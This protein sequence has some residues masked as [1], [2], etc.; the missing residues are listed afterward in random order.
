MNNK[1]Q[2]SIGN[3]IFVFLLFFSFSI[4]AAPPPLPGNPQPPALPGNPNQ[5][6]ALPGEQPPMEPSPG[7]CKQMPEMEGCP[8]PVLPGIPSNG[9]LRGSNY[10]FSYKPNGQAPGIEEF[11]KLG[12]CTGLKES[13]TYSYSTATKTKTISSDNIRTYHL[14]I[15][16][17][18][19]DAATGKTFMKA[20]LSQEEDGVKCGNLSHFSVEELNAKKRAIN[21]PPLFFVEGE[22]AKI[23]VRN[24]SDLPMTI[25]WHG[26]ILPNNQDGVPGITQNPIQPHSEF[27][28]QFYLQQN[29]TYWYHP[30]D[31]NEQHTKG[32]FIIFPKPGKEMITTIPSSNPAIETRYNHDRVILLTD[33]KKREPLKILNQLR[34]NQSAYAFDSKISRGIIEQF[35]CFDEF[36]ANFKNMKMF[37]MDKAD[38]WYDSF[39][40]NDET[41]LNCG[42]LGDNLEFPRR[43]KAGQKFQ[44]ISEFSKIKT[45]ER[46][47][48]RIINSSASTYFFVDYG[49]SK[50]LEPNQKTDMLIVAKDGE[51]VEP[52]YANQLKM[53]MGETY[54]VIVDVPEENTVYELRIKSIDDFKSERLARLLIGNT[55]SHIDQQESSSFLGLDLGSMFSSNGDS[56]SQDRVV[57]QAYDVP[58]QLCGPFP[59]ND[60]EP[61]EP[62]YAELNRRFEPGFADEFPYARGTRIVNYNL[63]LS[64]NMDDYHWQINGESGTKIE[65]DPGGSP[66]LT[67]IEGARN[68][69]TIKNTMMMGM[70]NHPWHLHGNFFRIVDPDDIGKA[71][72]DEI[73][74]KK[75]LLHTATISPGQTM[76][77]EI[78]ADPKYRGAWM[79]HCHNLYH[80]ANVMMMYLKYNTYDGKN[81]PHL[82]KMG[83]Q[84]AGHRGDWS[85]WDSIVNVSGQYV[86]LAGGSHAGT[87]GEG[88][89]VQFNY[90]G[91]LGGNN[92]YIDAIASA[93]KNLIGNKDYSISTTVK[94][95]MRVNECVYIDLSVEKDNTSRTSSAYLGKTIRVYNSEYKVIDMAV[96]AQYETDNET[97]QSKVDPAGRLTGAYTLPLGTLGVLPPGM[98]VTATAKGG[99]EGAYCG[100]AFAQFMAKLKVSPNVTF[101][102]IDCK[103]STDREETRCFANVMI[104]SDPINFGQGH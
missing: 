96:G 38:V 21:A 12:Y 77:L 36:M 63:D 8:P 95:C 1:L 16:S 15:S 74:A 51:P 46:V 101:T 56:N 67:I 53:G 17:D 59:E 41:C 30:H 47:R 18:D 45:G 91:N 4:V 102:L 93:S 71:N 81:L 98:V 72:E 88:V 34:N 66:Y 86:T 85:W 68:R 2:I 100:D 54:D 80:M 3:G 82:H 6:P 92:G 94:H 28:Y 69:I 32:A 76:I 87:H 57:K 40:I 79:F 89:D 55:G 49:N 78:Y 43:E 60:D 62:S 11:K 44:S 73:M 31:L 48:L 7:M 33:Y 20:M 52:I 90:R 83:E 103:G 39:F 25:H 10:K 84:I 50:S 13:P 75:P 24:D 14:R 70:M 19:T 104:G 99:C 64:G 27:T 29:G 26:L 37:W 23:V 61:T 9:R 97:H 22:T 42:P 35:Q 58:V 5:P 65:I